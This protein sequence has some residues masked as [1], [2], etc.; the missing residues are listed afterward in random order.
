MWNFPRIWSI[1]MG[2]KVINFIEAQLFRYQNPWKYALVVKVFRKSLGYEYLSY[3]LRQI[4]PFINDFRTSSIGYGHYTVV[5]NNAED[6]NRILYN[7]LQFV[8]GYF[9][10]IRKWEPYFDACPVTLDSIV[11]WVRINNLPR[12]LFH[13][14]ALKWLG[15]LIRPMLRM[16][17]FTSK[18]DRG[19]YARLCVLL[20]FN[21]PLV[22][23]IVVDCHPFYLQYERLRSLCTICRAI[24]H[25]ER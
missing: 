9:L 2:I 17:A 1:Q 16:V 14:E 8:N 18:A 5:L 21:K 25:G 7:G 4:W 13:R 24:G 3:K 6:H 12:E 15:E 10:A 23:T 11:A 19:K 22:H 20:N